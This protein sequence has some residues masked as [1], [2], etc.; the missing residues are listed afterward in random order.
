VRIYCRNVQGVRLHVDEMGLRAQYEG[1]DVVCLQEVFR[2]GGAHRKELARDF[3]ASGAHLYTPGWNLFGSGLL[4]LSRE[5]IREL[6]PERRREVRYPDP[7]LLARLS[8]ADFAAK[9]LV[10]F[11]L[12][13]GWIFHTH[14]NAGGLLADVAQRQRELD[15]VART[16]PGGSCLVCGDF[17]LDVDDPDETPRREGDRELL[18]ELLERTGLSRLFWHDTDGVLARGIEAKVDLLPEDGLSDHRALVIEA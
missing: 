11:G 12:S 3:P 4:T 5:P 10:G 9:G 6:P 7:P 8:K 16:L 13:W 2:L 17:N 18:A 14:L 1:F 15:L